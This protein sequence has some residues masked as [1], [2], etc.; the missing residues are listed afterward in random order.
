LSA[1]GEIS[2]GDLSWLIW[3]REAAAGRATRTAEIYFFAGRGDA[4][5]RASK[6]AIIPESM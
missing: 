4:Q 5:M 1:A 3:Q 2:G 6:P